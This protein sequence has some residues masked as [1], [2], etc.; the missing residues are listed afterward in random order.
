M[1]KIKLN[2]AGIVQML[3]SPEISAA[4]DAVASAKAAALGDGY[5]I[6]SRAGKKR[7]NARIV[8]ESPDAIQENLEKNTLVKAVSS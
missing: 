5:T 1:E 6:N 7:W 4:V 8:A 2:E 3:K